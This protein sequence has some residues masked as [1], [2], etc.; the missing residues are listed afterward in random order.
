MGVTVTTIGVRELEREDAQEADGTDPRPWQRPWAMGTRIAFRFC[1]VY[2][3]LFCLWF[4][5][6]TLAFV[7]FVGQWLPNHAVLWQW[8][9]LGPVARWVGG[10]LFGVNAELHLD[11]G[12]GD[13]AAMWVLLFCGL[14]FSA[15]ATAA[16]SVVDRR[17]TSY[18]RLGAR[19]FVF[20]RLFLGAQMLIY[21]F[22]KV[23]PIQMPAPPLSALLRPYGDFSSV[24]VLWL[25][26]GSSYPY[27]ILLGSAEVLAGALLFVPRTATLGALLSFLG[28]G[29]VFVLNMTFDVPVKILSFHLV[30][31][32]VVLLAPHL[33]RLANVFVLH[34]TPDPV[35][36]PPPFDTPRA[37]RIAT[38]VQ[39]LVGIVVLVGCVVLN[40]QGWQTYGG[41]R[42]KHD[43]YGIWSVT[44]FRLDGAERPP[45]T[46]D[47]QRWHRVVFDE[48]QLLTYQRMNGELVSTPAL[49]DDT[50]GT[51]ELP[52]TATFTVE[53]PTP[54]HLRL[55]GYLDGRPVAMSLQ[56][57][58]LNSFTLHNRGFSW[59]QDYGYF[60]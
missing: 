39:I 10:H 51:L 53:R 8:L 22:A 36:Y 30:L 26:V 55:A 25:Q 47:E 19:F 40:W 45:L 35:T 27:E 52:G 32:A 50:A 29:Q 16:W 18:P 13:Q 9:A 28:M 42:A 11:S 17:R 56:R 41:G 4:M 1:F 12:S 2:F 5:Q 58:D 23:I 57:V 49:F 34:R 21:G 59:V 44:E 3:A 33:R 54:D 24:S 60:G 31:M 7:G 15:V 6:F 14:V 20:L 43:A 37:N 38:V 46:T 48:P